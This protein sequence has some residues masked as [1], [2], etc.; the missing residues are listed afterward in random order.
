MGGLR[1]LDLPNG[2]GDV[3]FSFECLRRGLKNIYLGYLEATHLESASRG[4]RYEDW[5]ECVI[6]REYPDIL[7][8]MIR[9]DLGINRVPLRENSLV[10]SIQETFLSQVREKMPWLKPLKSA[11]RTGL[12]SLQ[13]QGD[14][15]A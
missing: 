3:A 1:S 10:H 13:R 14:N 11:A 8:R 7:Q 6:E 2:F 9:E 4:R 5:E 15:P 12:R